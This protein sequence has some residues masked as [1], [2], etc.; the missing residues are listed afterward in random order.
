MGGSAVEFHF[1]NS[2]FIPSKPLRSTMLASIP[3]VTR[4]YS[5]SP[6]DQKGTELNGVWLNLASPLDRK[7]AELNWV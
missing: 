3:L 6:L 7:G 5:A 4:S 1:L 2:G